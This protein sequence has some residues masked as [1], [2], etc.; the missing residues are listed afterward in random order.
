VKLSANAAAGLVT[1]VINT[2]GTVQADRFDA[3]NPG[4]IVLS[5][6]E[7]GTVA[8]SGTLSAKNDPSSP[9]LANPISKSPARTL[10]SPPPPCWTLRPAERRAT[11]GR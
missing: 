1:N 8:I 3:S 7:N 6:G 9:D 5:G 2:S 11:A 4:K 10:K